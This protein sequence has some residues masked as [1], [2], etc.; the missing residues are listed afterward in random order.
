MG[1]I[2][3]HN[4]KGFVIEVFYFQK[5]EVFEGLGGFWKIGCVIRR[6]NVVHKDILFEI[7]FFFSFK[8]SQGQRNRYLKRILFDGFIKNGGI[9]ERVSC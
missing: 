6:R 8:F 5:W 9:S 1:R 7:T 4:G 2:G 3:R